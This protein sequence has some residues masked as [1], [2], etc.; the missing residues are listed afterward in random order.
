MADTLFFDDWGTG[1]N[2]AVNT[3]DTMA[4][5]AELAKNIPPPEPGSLDRLMSMLGAVQGYG[6]ERQKLMAQ[7]AGRHFVN[8]PV[9][10]GGGKPEAQVAA[11]AMQQ[12]RGGQRRPPPLGAY[13][14]GGGRG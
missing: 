13:L 7:L 4:Y 9:A 10:G 11:L 3:P 5:A 14:L 12:G 2:L 1:S 6:D 8:P